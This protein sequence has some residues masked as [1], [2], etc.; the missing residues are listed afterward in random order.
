[1]TPQTAPGHRLLIPSYNTGP[2]LRDTVERAYAAWPAMLVVVD[3]STDGSDAVLDELAATRPGLQILRLAKNGGKGGAVL[4]GAR[5]LAA[6]GAT[7]IL[8]MDAD[9]QHPADRIVPMMRLSAA[10]PGNTVMGRPIF[11]PD[12]PPE[13]LKGRKLTIFWTDLETLW[14]GL[15]DTLFGMRVYPVNGLLAAFGQTPFARGYD[16]DPEVAVRLCWLGHR[17]VQLDAPVRYFKKSEDGVSHFNYLRDNIKLT[18]L[19]FRLVP[20]LLVLRLLPM[21]RH[22]RRWRAQPSRPAS[23]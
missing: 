18:F 22:R 14:C 15:G 13:R 23:P 4:A 16:F 5:H 10:N 20:E 17:P 11:G 2:R 3:G 12:V 1:M 19:H 9:G 21:L 6:Q 8:C 7:H